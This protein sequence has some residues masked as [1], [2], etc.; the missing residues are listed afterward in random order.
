MKFMRLI[1]VNL[2]RNKRRTVLTALSVTVALFLFATLRSVVTALDAVSEVGSETRLITRS[3]T[4]ITFALPQSYFERLRA[5]EGVRSVSW[6]NW[7]GGV[8]IDASNFFAQFAVDQE[9]YLAMYP[10]MAIP[11]DQKQAF[12]RERTAALVGSG[13]MERFGWSLGQN[14]TLQGTIFPGDWEFSIRAVYV[15]E[16][17]SF[18]DQM[19]FFHYDNLYEGVN[20]NIM[21]GWYVV[22]LEDPAAAPTVINQIDRMFENSSN[23]TKTETERAFNAGFVTMWGN[24]GF[25]VRAIGTA[26]FF[27]ILLVAAN[28]MMMAGR[29]RIGE[30]AVLKVLGFQDG[31]LFRLVL[32][33]SVLITVLG[34]ALGVFGSKLLFGPNNF[35]NAF[36]PGFEVEWS[37]VLLGLAMAVTLGVV[38]GIVPAWQAMRLPVIQAL[39]RVA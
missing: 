38:S 12:F 22:Q 24:I 6:A 7:F 37:T 13:L 11:E 27:A 28:T 23:P 36:I 2:L 1:W 26:V 14:I 25:L 31:L 32:V 35:V 19:F 4:G 5:Q 16:D 15:P 21:P 18:G 30:N 33:E 34:G 10:E 3:A 17:P 20:G 9:S 39:R 29:E 8:Y